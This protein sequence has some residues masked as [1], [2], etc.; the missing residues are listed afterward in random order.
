VAR[1][2]GGG[3]EAATALDAALTLIGFRPHSRRELE[4]KLARRAHEPEEI[5]GAL[6]RLVELGYL[7]DAAFA[8][9]V[10]RSRASRRGARAIAAE[11]R[12]KGVSREDAEAAL[13]EIDESAQRASALA[14]ARRVLR[15]AATAVDQK[16]AAAALV[17]RGFD[18]EVARSVVSEIVGG[19]QGD[20]D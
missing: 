11:L 7:D 2:A 18:F 17:R 8:R 9:A 3:A 6:A 13:T 16:K 1:S 19:R 10:V 20:L 14:L 5:A 15:P 4:L 12:A